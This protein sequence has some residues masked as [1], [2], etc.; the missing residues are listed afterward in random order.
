MIPHQEPFILKV[1]IIEYYRPL[2]LEEAYRLKKKYVN[3][4]GRHDV[5]LIIG[6]TAS[7]VYQTEHAKYLIDIS[8]IE[9]L[10]KIEEQDSGLFVG[11]AVTIQEAD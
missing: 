5:K 11:A 8:A 7:G 6:N 10:G 2:T 4:A 1:L 9:A 3:Q